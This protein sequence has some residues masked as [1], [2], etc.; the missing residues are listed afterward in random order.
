[1]QHRV[2]EPGLFS[3]LDTFINKSIFAASRE[4]LDSDDF[5]EIN[6]NDLEGGCVPGNFAMPPPKPA[7]PVV[8]HGRLWTIASTC[9][10]FVISFVGFP[11]SLAAST[12][13]TVCVPA[14][15]AALGSMFGMAFVDGFWFQLALLLLS[16]AAM[17]WSAYK[18]K[19]S[20]VPTFFGVIAAVLVLDGK[21]YQKDLAY[22]ALSGNLLMLLASL[23]NVYPSIMASR[24]P[25]F[26]CPYVPKSERKQRV[27]TVV[28]MSIY[29]AYRDLLDAVHGHLTRNLLLHQKR[30]ARK[31]G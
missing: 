30:R 4:R 2:R 12:C 31:V 9:I 8:K 28:I 5:V 18:A 16:I 13:G 20:F 23:M 11:M 10:T 1:M 25:N 6:L 7:G 22:M 27:I 19:R 17:A 3:S 14:Y 29:K 26:V 24:D 15:S 21:F